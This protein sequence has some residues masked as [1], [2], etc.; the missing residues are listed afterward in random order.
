[1]GCHFLLQGIF[2][3]QGS[4]LHFLH[5]PH[6]QVDPL[7]PPRATE[8]LAMPQR[9]EL[10]PIPLHCQEGFYEGDGLQFRLLLL[11]G[12]CGHRSPCRL[13]TPLSS[14]FLQSRGLAGMQSFTGRERPCFTVHCSRPAWS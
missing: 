14:P 13:P 11:T 2:L 7:P 12:N 10:A 4:N 8:W 5:L 3:T 6:W 1:M 9:A